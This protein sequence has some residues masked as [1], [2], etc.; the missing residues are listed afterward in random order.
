MTGTRPAA[1]SMHSSTTRRCSSWVRVGDSPVVPHGTRP[2]AP[3][4][5]CHSTSLWKARSSTLPSLN[6]VMRA[7]IEPLKVGMGTLGSLLEEFTPHGEAQWTRTIGFGPLGGKALKGRRNADLTRGASGTASRTL[8]ADKIDFVQEL[9]RL[10]SDDSRWVSGPY[11]TFF[12]R[13]LSDIVQL[14]Q[15]IVPSSS[16]LPGS[17]DVLTA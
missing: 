7:A 4:S 3:W 14:R 11:Q 9:A 5:I 2:C 17:G 16:R 15:I 1:A 6:G 10:F 8:R 13:I 12:C